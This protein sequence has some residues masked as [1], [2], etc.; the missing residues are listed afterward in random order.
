[1]S[2]TLIRQAGDSGQLYGSVS[3]RDLAEAMQAQGVEVDRKQ[4]QLDQPIKLLGP[5]K[6]RVGT[7]PAVT[8]AIT[9]NAA[10]T[11]EQAQPPS[12]GTDVSPPADAPTAYAPNA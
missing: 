8:I 2:V 10:R 7:H 5:H 9:A 12:T 11:H 4:V 1:M 6:V 3:V